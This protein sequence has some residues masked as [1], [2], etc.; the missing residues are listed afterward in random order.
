MKKGI[1]V[2]KE[3]L[4]K[5]VDAARHA[6]L[7]IRNYGDESLVHDQAAKDGFQVVD[8]HCNDPNCVICELEASIKETEKLL[9]REGMVQ[10]SLLPSVFQ[11]TKL[12]TIGVRI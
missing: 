6:A 12:K 10:L 1:N 11:D 4:K 2:K 9:S 7:F 5:L 8:G 3:T